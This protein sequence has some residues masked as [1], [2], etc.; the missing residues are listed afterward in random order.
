MNPAGD[1]GSHQSAGHYTED[2]CHC[3]QLRSFLYESL[4]ILQGSAAA[5]SSARRLGAVTP[6]PQERRLAGPG[7]TAAH[8]RRLYL[9]LEPTNS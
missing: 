6:F 3:L 1:R 7:D 8:L 4:R 5:F 9:D 2:A